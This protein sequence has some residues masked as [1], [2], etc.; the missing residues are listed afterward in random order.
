M[1]TTLLFLFIFLSASLFSQNVYIPDANFKA[2]LVG[3]TDINTNGDDEIQVSEASAFGSTI[4]CK[5]LEIYDLRG[6]E[7]FT[8]LVM[9]VC[10][11]N[12]LNNLDISFNI[13]L[14]TLWCSNNNL[15]ELDISK[16][17][18]LVDLDCSSNKLVNID[19]NGA[20]A[21]EELFCYNNKLVNIDL[22]GAGSLEEI[23]CDENQLTSLDISSNISLET[24]SCS[25]N[26][27]TELDISKN[28]ALTKLTCDENQLTSLDISKNIALTRLTC[29]ENQLTSLDVSKNIAL[30]KLTC[31]E[32]QLTSLD[33][34]KNIALTRLTCDENQLTSLD[35]SKNIALTKLRCESNKFECVKGV[36]I[37]CD[38]PAEYRCHDSFNQ[39]ID[40]SNTTY[41]PNLNYW[42]QEIK[43]SAGLINVNGKVVFPNA[44]LKCLDG[45]VMEV[46]FYYKND[47]IKSRK[48]YK[49]LGNGPEIYIMEER[50]KKSGDLKSKEC[51]NS[52]LKKIDCPED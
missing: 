3:K 31:D 13:S 9:L 42:D 37:Y 33:I 30:T 27:L 8:S 47:S 12:E 19:L 26:N 44:E 17:I 41:N 48:G 22:N 20:I 29:D 43:T 16:N 14:E 2:Y 34:S 46:T 28:I 15:T 24:L 18:A 6:V 21:L 52:E 1:K 45:Q 7:A 51:W 49:R 32:N 25:Y 10:S 50:F 4:N 39:S 40:R 38:L 35:V 5:S 23:D 11:S 36:S